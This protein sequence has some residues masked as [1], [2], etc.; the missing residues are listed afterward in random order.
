[1]AFD[2]LLLV[3]PVELRKDLLCL[4]F[5]LQMYEYL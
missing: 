2:L 3:D 1:M 4:R 5:H